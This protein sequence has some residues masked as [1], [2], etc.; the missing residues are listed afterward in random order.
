VPTP[1][2]DSIRALPKTNM[3]FVHHP[4]FQSLVLPF[5]FAIVG[6]ALLRALPGRAALRWWPLGAVLGLLATLAVLPGFDWPATSRAQK[7]PWIVLAGLALAAASVA[8]RA[9]S[10]RRGRWATWL[11][12]VLGWAVASVWLDGGRTEPLQASL[13]VLA[14]AVLLAL[15]ALGGGPPSARPR[16]STGALPEPAPTAPVGGTTAIAALTVAA[17][18]L[19]ALA[20][21]GGSLLLA[22]LALMLGTVAAVP[23]LWAWLRP[24]S[25]LVVPTAVLMPLGLAWLSI[26]QSLPA[27]GAGSAVGPALVAL[28]LAMPLLM[29]HS[30]WA[31]RHPRWAPLAAVTFAAVPVVLALVWQ[32]FDGRSPVSVPGTEHNDDP[33]YAPR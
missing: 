7:L 15:L 19:G 10:S 4:A 21:N 25:G 14:G 33:Y 26:A 31:A 32:F 17:V 11:S 16:Y 22:Q 1:E 12:G 8:W 2:D 23:G 30:A 6:M 13:F 18:G 20:A 24:S 3:S 28:A 5:A 29:K 9:E 27:H